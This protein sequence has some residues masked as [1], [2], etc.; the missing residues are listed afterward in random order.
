MALVPFSHASPFHNAR[1][2]PIRYFT[3][4]SIDLKIQQAWKPDGRGGTTLGFGGYNNE[5][6]QP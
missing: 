1:A 6:N 2:L 4:C 5:N 3:F